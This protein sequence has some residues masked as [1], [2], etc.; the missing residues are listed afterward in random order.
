MNSPNILPALGGSAEAK[1]EA[2]DIR[3]S[4]PGAPRAR[5]VSLISNP[6]NTREEDSCVGAS[7]RTKDES[8]TLP[9]ES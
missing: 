6:M 4:G 7:R 8:R 2:A 3:L 9:D 1:L 5:T